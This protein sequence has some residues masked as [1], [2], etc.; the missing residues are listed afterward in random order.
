MKAL[1]EKMAEAAAAEASGAS[2]RGT[3]SH[4]ASEGDLQ[5]IMDDYARATARFETMGGYT[6]E[7]RAKAILSGLGFSNDEFE[8]SADVL[9]GGER[10]RL[11]R[12]SCCFRARTA[13][14]G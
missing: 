2:T 10:I 11:A 7:P 9:S 1:E 13:A 8:K 14:P 6:L 3:G 5:A 4:R 12:Q